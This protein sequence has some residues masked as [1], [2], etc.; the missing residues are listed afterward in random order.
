[1]DKAKYCRVLLEFCKD[2]G[3][4]VVW[5]E[6]L[7]TSKILWSTYLKIKGICSLNAL[8]FK[9]L[10]YIGKNTGTGDFCFNDNNNLPLVHCLT[11]TDFMPGFCIGYQVSQWSPQLLGPGPHREQHVQE[12]QEEG[13]RRNTVWSQE[14]HALC[15]SVATMLF[16][17]G[18]ALV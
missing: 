3:M 5:E 14:H 9:C 10:K 13:S 8:K 18:V 4:G 15:V 7:T 1:M 16:S 6:L 2:I 11:Y 17:L 12:V